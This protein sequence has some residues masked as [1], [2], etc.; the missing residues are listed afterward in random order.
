MTVRPDSKLPIQTGRCPHI[1]KLDQQLDSILI[2][3]DPGMQI[4]HATRSN[5]NPVLLLLL[6]LPIVLLLE[7]GNFHKRRR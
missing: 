7:Q 4:S 6:L 1:G 5:H 2:D 3:H